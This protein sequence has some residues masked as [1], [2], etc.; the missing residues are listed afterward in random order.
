MAVAGAEGG[1]PDVAGFG[2]GLED[3]ALFVGGLAEFVFGD[4]FPCLAVG[5]DADAVFAD[6]AVLA[7]VVAV[8][9][10][11]AGDA[12]GVRELEGDDV[13]VGLLVLA[14]ARVPEGF[15]VAVE[16]LGGGVAAGLGV[17]L[18]D[19]EFGAVVFGQVLA[20]DDPCGFG[21][22]VLLFVFDAD[23]A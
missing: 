1:E 12:G 9:E 18:G 22:R 5:A 21:G 8:L 17:Y 13:G 20:G 6:V 14:V 19:A 3:D 10:V 11:E 2:G 23:P 15:A 16:E 4:V 7:A